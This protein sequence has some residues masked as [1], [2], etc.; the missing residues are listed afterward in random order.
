MLLFLRKKNLIRL[1]T[2]EQSRLSVAVVKSD[3]KTIKLDPQRVLRVGVVQDIHTRFIRNSRSENIKTS[4]SFAAH[5]R[6]INRIT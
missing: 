3:V 2:L 5:K 1:S 6:L 4:E